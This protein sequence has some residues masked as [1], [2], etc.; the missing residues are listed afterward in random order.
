MNLGTDFS[1]CSRELHG[2][3][4][5]YISFYTRTVI[6]YPCN[7][8]N[9]CLKK[10]NGCISTHPQLMLQYLFFPINQ[11]FFPVTIEATVRKMILKS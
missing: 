2:L 5:I 7:P 9:P 6:I 1:L 3:T 11:N 4:R 10:T 8:R